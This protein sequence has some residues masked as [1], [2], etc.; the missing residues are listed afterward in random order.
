M[1]QQPLK[2]QLTYFNPQEVLLE[3]SRPSLTR[4]LGLAFLPEKD[5]LEEKP[6]A[7]GTRQEDCREATRYVA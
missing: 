6:V 3:G 1:K 7:I 2:H 4:K 5:C